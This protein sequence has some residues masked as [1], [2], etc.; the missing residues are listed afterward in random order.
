MTALGVRVRK[1]DRFHTD[2]V[3]SSKWTQFQH[4]VNCP[5]ITWAIRLV[6][7][8]LCH[9]MHIYGRSISLMQMPS[10]TFTFAFHRN[11]ELSLVSAPCSCSFLQSAKKKKRQRISACAISQK[12]SHIILLEVGR[13]VMKENDD[14]MIF[15][16]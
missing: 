13:R 16:K 2:I 1:Y 7:A 9:V 8:M 11:C 10:S 4:Q 12:K 15:I 6:D 14:E 5:F 3:V